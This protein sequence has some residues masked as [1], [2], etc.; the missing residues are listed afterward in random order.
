[1]YT[2][3]LSIE[4]GNTPSTA[5]KES[6]DATEKYNNVINAFVDQTAP[7]MILQQASES[8]TRW[9]QNQPKSNID[10]ALMGIKMNICTD[11][12]RTTCGSKMLDNFQSP[13]D[14]TVV[15]LLKEAGVIIAGKTNM[16]E[17]G[18]GSY[19]VHSSAGVAINPHDLVRRGIKD[20]EPRTPGGSSGGSA[21]AVAAN[22][23]FAALG[24]DTGGSVRLP[25]SYCGVVGF[26]PSYGRISRWGL[27]AYGSSLDCVGILAKTVNDVK[28]VYDV[29]SKED[30][31]DSTCLTKEQRDRITRALS[32]MRTPNDKASADKPLLGVR[33]G[34]PKE[35]NIKELS[36]AS[37]LLWR[38]GIMALKQAGATIVPV[39]MPRTKAALSSY[40][41]LA[42]AEASSNLQRYDGVRYGHQSQHPDEA[43]SLYAHTR[44]EGFGDE[45]KRRIIAGTFVL[46][47]GSYENYFVRAQK[48]RMLIRRDFDRVFAR[49]NMMT[50]A[51]SDAD[52][53][54]DS[55][56]DP[57]RVHALLT[58]A[59]VTTAPRI[60]QV[61]GE[62]VDPLNA[63]LD[64][65]LTVPASLA[66]IPSMSVPFGTC[67]QDGQP[68]GLQVMAQY[69][70]EEMVFAVSRALE[71]AGQTM[72]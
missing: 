17:F 5:A 61:L 39:S 51:L 15:Q 26:K 50:A 57:S 58:P 32:T 55:S 25:G 52:T 18:M 13:F 23:C 71:A 3:F 65:V 34:I 19:N 70:D 6:L 37:M 63:Y 21:A 14:A 30:P 24:S 29:V 59:A 16:D 31:R 28:A 53:H 46:T 11:T 60:S 44:T 36:Q 8:T 47:S 45:V 1:M 72:Q 66:G 62:G 69:G 33:I 56:D 41:T 4:Q 12:L 67:E 35:Y 40:F 22:L 42:T 10:G 49:P 7:E 2:V 20:A 54:T 9:E 48:A 38:R 68:V 43:D 27:V 64:D